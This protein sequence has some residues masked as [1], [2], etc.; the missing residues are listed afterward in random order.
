MAREATK[1]G[2]A[3]LRAGGFGR[4]RKNL[5]PVVTG[6]LKGG[7]GGVRWRGGGPAMAVPHGGG[8]GV[9]LGGVGQ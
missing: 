7:G 5:R 8:K 4:G 6:R 1:G 2:R 9:L 3:S